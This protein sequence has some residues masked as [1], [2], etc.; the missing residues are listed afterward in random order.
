MTNIEL[1]EWIDAYGKEIFSFCKWLTGCGP[2]AEELYQDTWLV[3]VRRLEEL[4]AAGNVKS[5][6]LSVALRLWKN[7]RRRYARRRRI[8]EEQF[9]G[10]ICGYGR[11][12]QALSPEQRLLR[13]EREQAVR[14]AV[15][16]LPWRQR[17]IVL[18]FYMEEQPLGRIAEITGLPLGTVKSRLY[19]ARKALYQKLKDLEENVSDI[20][21]ERV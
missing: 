21:E 11:E 9:S 16:E 20:E 6:C 2:E 7:K 18:L 14:E 10:E 17:I 3:V 8:E 15:E 4:D 12:W 13:Q 1:A 5:Y 19:H